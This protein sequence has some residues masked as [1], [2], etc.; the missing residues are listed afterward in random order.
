[1]YNKA[2][3]TTNNLIALA[4]RSFTKDCL[5]SNKHNPREVY[6][7][8]NSLLKPRKAKVL[9]SVQNDASLSDQFSEFF[10][11]KVSTI[12]QELSVN[13]PTNIF[14]E[15]KF[16]G[17][18]LENFCLATEDEIRETIQKSASKSCSL[19]PLPTWILKKSEVELIPVITQIVNTS[20]VGAEVCETLKT[21]HVTPL[22][23]KSTLDRNVLKNYRPVSNLS[24]ISKIIEKIVLNRFKY[25]LCENNLQ[26]KFQSAYKKQHS[27]ESALLRVHND[28]VCSLDRKKPVSLVLL[29]LSAAFDTI[30]QSILLGRLETRY[31]I[32]GDA[33]KWFESYLNGRQ[34]RIVIDTSQSMPKVLDFDVPQGSV[35]GPVL[36]TAYTAPIGDIIREMGL[37]Y[38]FYAD[39]TQLYVELD[40]SPDTTTSEL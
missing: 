24:F 28:I 26:E 19:D 5:L 3:T 17:P 1:M 32:S 6:K 34:S 2:R 18:T 23:K 20:L 27:T 8:T 37:D 12:R 35:L 14:T 25:H 38:H 13:K 4:K 9:P 36:F 30:D 15:K 10:H 31:G 16:E 39:D 33:L 11:D 40:P 7:I 22:I 21:A 29:D